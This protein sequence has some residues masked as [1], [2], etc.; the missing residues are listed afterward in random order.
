M[1]AFEGQG[2]GLATLLKTLLLAVL[3]F[4]FYRYYVS[5]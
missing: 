1:P 4:A 5:S 2:T 3:A